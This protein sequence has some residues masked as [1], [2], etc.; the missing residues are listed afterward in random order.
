MIF[1]ISPGIDF[2]GRRCEI[3]QATPPESARQRWETSSP[4]HMA[5][6]AMAFRGLTAPHRAQPDNPGQNAALRLRA[7]PVEKLR[8]DSPK[9]RADGVF[10]A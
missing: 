6:P 8:D 2:P 3:Q 10:K 4:S 5:L 7:Q 9:F 1:P